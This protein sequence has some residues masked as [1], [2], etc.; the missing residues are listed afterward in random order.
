MNGPTLFCGGDA[1]REK[2]DKW[3]R[4][5]NLTSNGQLWAAPKKDASSSCVQR[6]CCYKVVLIDDMLRHVGYH[7]LLYPQLEV[8]YSYNG[9]CGS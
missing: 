4:A 8:V 3:L 5:K 6:V 1:R 9:L 7:Y 2:N